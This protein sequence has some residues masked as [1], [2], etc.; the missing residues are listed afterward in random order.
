M[1]CNI[2]PTY[3]P[4]PRQCNTVGLHKTFVRIGI[5]PTYWC[6]TEECRLGPSIVPRGVCWPVE[7]VSNVAAFVRK[8]SAEWMILASSDI[9]VISYDYVGEQTYVVFTST[10]HI[11]LKSDYVTISSR[12]IMK[13]QW[14]SGKI[15]RCHRWAP[16]SIPG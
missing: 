7:T 11:L 6:R 2:G 14:F 5:Q 12:S 8:C 16:G 4:A 9:N 10:L 3:H 13:H 1:K 15:H